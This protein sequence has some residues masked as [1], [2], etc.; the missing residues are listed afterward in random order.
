[1]QEHIPEHILQQLVFSD[2]LAYQYRLCVSTLTSY[3]LVDASESN[4]G[5]NLDMH[6]LIPS[7]LME[8]VM[9]QPK[10][11]R[12]GLTTMSNCLLGFLPHRDLEIHRSLSDDGLI[13]L[14]PHVYAVAEKAVWICDD[15]TCDA[16]VQIACLIALRSRNVD[17]AAY[18][19]HEWL[20]AT[21]QL[22]SATFL[23]HFTSNQVSSHSSSL[24]GLISCFIHSIVSYG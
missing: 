15:Q 18:L 14:I 10:E 21:D 6:P 9:R 4:E 17:V 24:D 16:L 3:A 7:T 13:A 11:L 12:Y 22:A 20:K 5:C 8:R 19:C 2:S 23:R 1:M